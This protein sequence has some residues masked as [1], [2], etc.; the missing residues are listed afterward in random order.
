MISGTMLCSG[1][2]AS[3]DWGPASAPASPNDRLLALSLQQQ[4][5]NLF[6]SA[7]AQDPILPGG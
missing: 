6:Q 2:M 4:T 3:A 5:S 1:R 7:S